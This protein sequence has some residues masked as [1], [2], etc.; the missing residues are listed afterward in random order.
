MCL[1]DLLD[2][3]ISYNPAL[4]RLVGSATAAILLS[5]A[6]YWQKRVPDKRPKGCPGKGWWYHSSEEWKEE[7]ALSRNEQQTARKILKRTS[8]W[9]E[10]KQGI[11]CRIWYKVDFVKLENEL[12]NTEFAEIRQTSMTQCRRKDGRFTSGKEAEV[13]M[14]T[15]KN[16]SEFTTE[17]TTKPVVGGCQWD[18]EDH[19]ELLTEYGM[20]ATVEDKGSYLGFVR[21]R[22]EAEGPSTIDLEQYQGWLKKR[23]CQIEMQRKLREKRAEEEY[24]NSPEGLTSGAA[25]AA[26]AC[27]EVRRMLRD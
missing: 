18:L 1:T 9:K 3:P 25:A 12:I 19:I 16:T 20:S 27:A 21:K 10:R 6:I 23:A 13:R 5:Q 26:V 24:R 11:P 17:T 14:S 7:T 15:S 8:F 22:L 4:A 2:R